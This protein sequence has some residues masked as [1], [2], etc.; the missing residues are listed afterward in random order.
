MVFYQYK[1]FYK[2]TKF[3]MGM[4]NMSYKKVRNF[5]LVFMCILF[6]IFHNNIALAS[7]SPDKA[8]KDLNKK[9]AD[10]VNY[11]SD[12]TV[13][14]SDNF[15]GDNNTKRFSVKS[16]I[17]YDTNT[18]Y[19]ES[20]ERILNLSQPETNY[21]CFKKNNKNYVFSKNI[22]KAW[23]QIYPSKDPF[24]K[25]QANFD[26]LL[27]LKK[28]LNDYSS[29]SY[30]SDNGPTKKIKIKTNPNIIPNWSGF[31]YFLSLDKMDIS[32]CS[33][34]KN[35]FY[36]IPIIITIINNNLYS[37][38]IDLSAY[39]KMFLQNKMLEAQKPFSKSGQKTYFSGINS[40]KGT[41]TLK[42]YFYN[43]NNAK[44]APVKTGDFKVR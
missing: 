23:S 9:L 13:Y 21:Y 27:F 42:T 17:F 28:A 31:K 19:A 11:E 25:Y 5:L 8:L 15:F 3:K 33:Y 41:Y 6:F 18:I 40:I 35:C 34:I 4:F 24:D 10:I 36:D 38:E 2:T 12:K 37:Y 14:I 44:K 30:V 39:Y 22:K 32:L 1:Y 26:S 7:T 43:I 16:F 29:S 20:K